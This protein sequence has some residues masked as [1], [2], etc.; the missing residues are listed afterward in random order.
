VIIA[1]FL[2]G[3]VDASDAADVLALHQAFIQSIEI[4][5]AFKSRLKL[6]LSV[7]PLRVYLLLRCSHRPLLWLLIYTHRTFISCS[8]SSTILISCTTSISCASS[9][10]ISYTSSF[11]IA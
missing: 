10:T 4:V 7:E 11:S 1:R 6:P 9:I 8:S 5:V 3:G 2:A